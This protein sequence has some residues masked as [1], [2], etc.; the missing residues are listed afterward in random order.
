M[1]KQY[2]KEERLSKF[3]ELM[4]LHTEVY[5]FWKEDIP[6]PPDLTLPEI[7][8]FRKNQCDPNGVLANL[9]D[10]QRYELSDR[11]REFYSMIGTNYHWIMN[12]AMVEASSRV[13]KEFL[14]EINEE[15]KQ[16]DERE[17]IQ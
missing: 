1:T 2:A 12:K 11:I 5:G 16:E 17:S 9:T 10:D 15:S 4:D 8:E 6:I 3:C 14:Q 7:I 13:V